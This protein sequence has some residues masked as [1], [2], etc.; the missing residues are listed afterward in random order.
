MPKNRDNPAEM[1]EGQNYTNN[2]T[3]CTNERVSHQ[4]SPHKPSKCWREIIE[5]ALMNRINHYIYST[6][7]V[8]KNHYAFIQQTSTTD[9]IKALKILFRKDLAK[10]KSQQ[11]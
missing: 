1:E 3:V 11:L 8:N 5:R 10:V 2:G 9:V 4:I 6:E 7:F